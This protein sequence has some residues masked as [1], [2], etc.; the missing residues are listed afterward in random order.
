[1]FICHII[2]HY[3]LLSGTCHHIVKNEN[4]SPSQQLYYITHW[5]ICQGFCK[6]NNIIFMGAIKGAI[7]PTTFI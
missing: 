2:S 6:K 1:M 4:A 3:F 5:V 7:S